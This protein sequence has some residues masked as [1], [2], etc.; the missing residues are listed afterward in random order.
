MSNQRNHHIIYELPPIKQCRS[1]L[2]S[3]YALQSTH[4]VLPKRA[5]A[6]A[7]AGHLDL[8]MLRWTVRDGNA[9]QSSGSSSRQHAVSRRSAAHCKNK[10][11]TTGTAS[12]PLKVDAFNLTNIS[13]REA[14]WQSIINCVARDKHNAPNDVHDNT[15]LH[16]VLASAAVSGGQ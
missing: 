2:E 9:C 12:L 6:R 10:Q 15:A 8:L 5:R 13:E 3:N 14:R 4:T 1:I 11:N 16:I 7:H